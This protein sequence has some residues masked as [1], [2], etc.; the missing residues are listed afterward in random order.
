MLDRRKEN[1][2]PV[3]IQLFISDLFRKDQRGIHDLET[4]VKVEDISNSGLCFLSECVLPVDY[5]F[6]AKVVLAKHSISPIFTTV[7]IIHAEV[8][9]RRHYR[10]GCEFTNL[11]KNLGAII[12]AYS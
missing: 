1:R 9:D 5:Y 7:K 3:S 10:Y 12:D 2:H 4:P 8:V 6:N 11:P